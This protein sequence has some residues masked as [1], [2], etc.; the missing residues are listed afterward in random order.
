MGSGRWRAGQVRRC[1]AFIS[2]AFEGRLEKRGKKDAVWETGARLH[3]QAKLE[4]RAQ[5]TKGDKGS[6]SRRAE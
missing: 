3:N 5:L 4:A 6:T 1:R 2:A